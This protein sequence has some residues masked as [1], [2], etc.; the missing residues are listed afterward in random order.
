MFDTKELSWRL[1]ET[2]G[3][4]EAYLSYAS[5]NTKSEKKEADFGG[6][7]PYRGDNNQRS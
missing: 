3:S 2:T 4:V 5:E 6:N 1:F 7:S